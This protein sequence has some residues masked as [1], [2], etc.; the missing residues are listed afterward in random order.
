MFS[1]FFYLAIVPLQI[2]LMIASTLRFTF[3][4]MIIVYINSFYNV[5]YNMC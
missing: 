2:M 4:L 1:Y 5:M 3:Y